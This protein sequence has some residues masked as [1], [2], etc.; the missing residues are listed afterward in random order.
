MY[1]GADIDGE[2]V[3]RAREMDPLSNRKLMAYYRGRTA[4]LVEPDTKPGVVRE[5]AHAPPPERPLAFVRLGEEGIDV[6]RSPEDIKRKVLSA[7]EE[8]DGAALNCD[9]WNYLF[10]EVTGVESPDA[11]GGC[12]PPGQRGLPMRFDVWFGWLKKQR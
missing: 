6:L 10:T 12:F 4:W 5:Y 11:G 3:V 2:Q 1:N 9:Q 8:Y 7:A